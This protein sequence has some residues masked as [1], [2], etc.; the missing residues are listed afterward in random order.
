MTSLRDF[1]I[2]D[3]VIHTARMNS[4]DSGNGV[5]I[6]C[7]SAVV[8]KF[9]KGSNGIYDTLWF[10]SHPNLLHKITEHTP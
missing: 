2:G 5:V 9:N 4:D 8:I 1:K 3:K 7:G 6:G 10:E